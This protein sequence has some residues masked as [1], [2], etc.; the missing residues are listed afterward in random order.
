MAWSHSINHTRTSPFSHSQCQYVPFHFTSVLVLHHTIRN[1]F[2]LNWNIQC[3][4]NQ[5]NNL[6]ID[7]IRIE[8]PNI[9]NE[10]EKKNEQFQQCG[11]RRNAQAC[12]LIKIDLLAITLIGGIRF[13]PPLSSCSYISQT[14]WIQVNY[15]HITVLLRA[16]YAYKTSHCTNIF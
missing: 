10:E 9:C 3:L 5:V 13:L 4:V 15:K 8:I 2:H 6:L 12:H 11:T 1:H 16:Y 14:N 7:E